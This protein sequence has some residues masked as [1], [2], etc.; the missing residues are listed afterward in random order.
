MASSD[1]KH[2]WLRPTLSAVVYRGFET[3]QNAP[4]ILA[5][6]KDAGRVGPEQDAA[7]RVL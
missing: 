4:E 1:P 5:K 6:F 2:E 3:I 7:E